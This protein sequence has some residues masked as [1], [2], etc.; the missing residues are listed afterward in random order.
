MSLESHT[1]PG[2]IIEAAASGWRLSVA[3][4]ASRHYRLAQLD[5][6]ALLPRRHFAARPPATLSLSA[7]AAAHS[8]PGTWGFGLWNDPFGIA[9]WLKDRPFRLP[10]LPNSVWF[11]HASRSNYLSFR[12]DKPAS[13]FLAQAFSAPRFHPLL[14]PAAMALPI[15]RARTRQLLSRIVDED[16]ARLGVDVTA[17]HVYR[18]EWRADRCIFWVDETR[19]LEA[20]VSPRPPLGLVIWIDNQ[21]AAFTPDGSIRWGFETNPADAWLE[22]RALDVS[23]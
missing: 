3:Q 13:G 9:L 17:W 2:G 11:F 20:R 19:V 6:Y 4:G 7:R 22:I 14:I 10:A 5:D 15:W 12:N 1:T 18:L 8:L 16:S 21:F 23:A